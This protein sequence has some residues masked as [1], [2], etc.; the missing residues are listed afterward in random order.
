MSHVHMIFMVHHESRMYHLGHS[1]VFQLS[2]K[3]AK[4]YDYIALIR[5]S[6]P[7]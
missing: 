6:L 3:M 4:M 5:Q 1:F 7:C 2:C